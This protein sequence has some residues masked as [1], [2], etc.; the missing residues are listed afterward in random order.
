MSLCSDGYRTAQ[1]PL[2]PSLSTILI[3]SHGGG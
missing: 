1:E 2:H 3:H